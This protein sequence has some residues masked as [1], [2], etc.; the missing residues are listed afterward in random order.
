MQR[1]WSHSGDSRDERI[2]E[3]WNR[4][5]RSRIQMQGDV[6]YYAFL[7][8]RLGSWRDRVVGE[9]TNFVGSYRFALEDFRWRALRLRPDHLSDDGFRLALRSQLGSAFCSHL[10]ASGI[11]QAVAVEAARI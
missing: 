9:L 8:V 6:S 2:M 1:D 11:P 7:E 10:M 3:F 5:Q 4:L